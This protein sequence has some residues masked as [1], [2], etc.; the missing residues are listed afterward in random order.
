MCLHL[1]TEFPLL[2][3]LLGLQLKASAVSLSTTRT[4]TARNL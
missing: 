1:H 3:L 2:N 4:Y